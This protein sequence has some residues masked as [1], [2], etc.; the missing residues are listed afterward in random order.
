MQRSFKFRIYPDRKQ[1]AR[2]N[3]SLE[4]CYELYNVLLQMKIDK[5]KDEKII[6]S[7]FDLNKIATE[8]DVPI[9]SQVK[10]NISKRINDAFQHFFR[11]VKE[12]KGKA[13]FP[14][15]KSSNR[16]KSITFP[17]SGFKINHKKIC[18]SK[19]GNIDIVLHR[20]IK[21]KIKT[22]TIKRCADRWYA[23]FSCEGIII[24]KIKPK[25]RKVGI[26]VGLENFATLSNGEKIENP[27]FLKKSE[28]KLTRLQ[29]R[30]SKKKKGSENR[31][32]ARLKVARQHEKI[33][34]QRNDFLHN[35]TAKIVRRF[36]IIAV[37]KLNINGMIKNRYLAKSISDVGWNR[38]IQMLSYKVEN[39]GGKVK[40]VN[41]KYTSQICSHCGYKQKMPLSKRTFNCSN[42]G[43]KINRDLNA[44][45]NIL[46]TSG[47]GEINDSGQNVRPLETKANLK[48]GVSY[49]EN[50]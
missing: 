14:R 4:S 24:D 31:R 20:E 47:Q 42:C 2:M 13:G 9:H 3:Q 37:E 19:I 36:K 39:T 7:Q 45:R 34:N 48:E 23:I 18:L 17:Q 25:E 5:Y 29:R 43:F 1:E 12:K 21:G 8:L 46:N 41:P 44:S 28:R 22:L 35:Q 32:K 50:A 30:L 15:F 16:Y 40:L 11:R 27:R 33:F 6:L 38:F 10:Q 26:D 49:R